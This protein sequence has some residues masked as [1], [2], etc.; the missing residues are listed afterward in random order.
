M[1]HNDC[2]MSGQRQTCCDSRSEGPRVPGCRVC[3]TSPVVLGAVFLSGKTQSDNHAVARNGCD[4]G[5]TVARHRATSPICWFGPPCPLDH[6]S[7]VGAP[8]RRR[9]ISTIEA[10]NTHNK[11]SKNGKNSEA[12]S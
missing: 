7:V 8:I 6:V 1:G 4:L 10:T 12:A 2:A 5:L 3:R 11:N 9:R